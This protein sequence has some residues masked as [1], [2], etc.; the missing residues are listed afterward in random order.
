MHA[1]ISGKTNINSVL[2]VVNTVHLYSAFKH[3]N[4]AI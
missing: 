3:S 4:E 1:L 2:F